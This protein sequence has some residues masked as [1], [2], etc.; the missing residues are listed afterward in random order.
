MKKLIALLLVM[1]LGV[2]GAIFPA[3]ASTR[4][5][6]KV[7]SPDHGQTFAYGTE[8]SRVW[9]SR[10]KDKHLALLLDFTNDP[11]VDRN[12]PRQYDDFTFHFPDVK[13]GP[14]GRTF[15]YHTSEGRSVPV[16]ARR[17]DLFGIDEIKLL[18]SSYLVVKKPH[19]YVSLT[20]IV[21][22]HPF[23]VAPE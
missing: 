11:F 22:D 8:Q 2:W 17:P 21:Q 18:D 9:A 13:L 23:P 5:I 4:H 6:W 15:F 16:A 10:G 1:G 19:G 3:A 14:D 20:L 7:S 12:N